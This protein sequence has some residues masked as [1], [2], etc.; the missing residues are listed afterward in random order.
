MLL[1]FTISILES[2]VNNWTALSYTNNWV[3]TIIFKLITNLFILMDGWLKWMH[4]GRWFSFNPRHLCP[5]CARMLGQLSSCCFNKQRTGKNIC[6]P[7][8]N[9]SA[10]CIS[11]SLILIG[12]ETPEN[13]RP[14]TAQLPES[15]I[16]IGPEICCSPAPII[17]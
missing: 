15:L 16:L 4:G 13:S 6:Q 17:T 2:T 1:S 9:Q 14:I 3:Y 7:A 8:A 5:P 12:S 10:A 11:L